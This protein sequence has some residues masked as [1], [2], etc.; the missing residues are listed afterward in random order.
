MGYKTKIQLIERKNS[1]QWYVFFP[2]A[3]A[4]A[5]E[6]EKGEELEIVIKSRDEIVIKRSPDKK[7]KK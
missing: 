4:R 7:R 2:M 1:E 5:L 3:L 6:L